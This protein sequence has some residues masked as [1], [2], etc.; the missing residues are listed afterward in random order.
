MSVSLKRYN[1]TTWDTLPFVTATE[2]S[3]LLNNK[4]NLNDVLMPTNPFG[5]RRLYINALNNAFYAADKRFYVTTTIH[6]KVVS[7]VTYPYIDTSKA[8]T[9][10]NYFVDSPVVST[11]SSVNLFD[12]SYESNPGSIPSDSYMKVAIQF[13]SAGSGTFAGYPYGTYYLSYYYT[14][15]PDSAQL[16]VYNTYAPQ[17]TGWKLYNFSDYIGTNANNQYIQ[18]CSDEGD[19]SRTKV[20]FIIQGNSAHT[21]Q[22][23]QIDYKLT[24]PNLSQDGSTFTKYGAQKSYFDFTFGNQTNNNITISPSGN[25]SALSFKE[26]GELLSNKYSP[27]AGSSS[28]TTCSRGTFG[29]MASQSSSSYLPLSAGSTNP[30]TGHLFLNGGS[31]NSSTGTTT[32]IVMARG[33]TQQWALASNDGVFI[34]NPSTTSTSNQ[35]CYYFN[36]GNIVV[37]KING[38]TLANGCSLTYT[39]NGTTLEIT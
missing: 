3:S 22:V 31:S 35:F 11:L 12:G 26:N 15:T 38:Y 8:V 7:G 14:Y 36:T 21:T 39:L 33:T 23:T 25:I 37:P 20:Q 18:S 1:G 13:N 17:T 34:V 16:R 28:L 19:Y 4:I 32:Q 2:V 5:G 30:L 29:T 10:D 9:D 27:I 6:K 24:R